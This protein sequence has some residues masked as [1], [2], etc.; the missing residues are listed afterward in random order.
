MQ[1][2]RKMAD[3]CPIKEHKMD[4]LAVD[5]KFAIFLVMCIQAAIDTYKMID[6]NNGINYRRSVGAGQQ[7]LGHV[8]KG[9]LQLVVS[10]AGHSPQI[11]LKLVVPAEGHLSLVLLDHCRLIL[12]RA[13]AW[14]EGAALLQS[15][16]LRN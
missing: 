13:G 1:F 4:K 14:H 7:I 5:A 6:S 11:V 3:K 9:G 2:K 12:I 8:G 10:G 15:R 16:V